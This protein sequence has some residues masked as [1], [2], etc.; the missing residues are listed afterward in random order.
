MLRKLRVLWLYW[1]VMKQIKKDKKD[2]C[3][4]KNGNFLVAVWYIH[5]K[6]K[7]VVSMTE[8]ID[9]YNRSHIDEMFTIKQYHQIWR[10]VFKSFLKNNVIS[11][12][13]IF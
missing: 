3:L 11:S 8:I 1:K 7:W 13:S 10:N 6:N 12:T 5:H 9:E 2:H 4:Y